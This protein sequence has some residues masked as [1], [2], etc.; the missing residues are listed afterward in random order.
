MTLHC[1]LCDGS[2]VEYRIH[3]TA[4]F[5]LRCA[6]NCGEY[7][8]THALFAGLRERSHWDQDRSNSP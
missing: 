5:R 2:A 1:H 4:V 8:Y 6:K 3:G 7:D